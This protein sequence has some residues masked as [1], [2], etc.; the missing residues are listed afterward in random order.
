MYLGLA[1]HDFGGFLAAQVLE[2]KI[3]KLKKHMFISRIRV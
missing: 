2:M 1:G 3:V